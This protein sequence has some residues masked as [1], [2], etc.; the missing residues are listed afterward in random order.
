MVRCTEVC[1]GFYLY[2][3]DEALGFHIKQDIIN[4]CTV[5]SIHV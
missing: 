1:I 2:S 4:F 3:S 5:F